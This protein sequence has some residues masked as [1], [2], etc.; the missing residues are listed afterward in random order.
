LSNLLVA[1]LLGTIRLKL[2]PS[3]DQP[4]MRNMTR[5]DSLVD[6]RRIAESLPIDQEPPQVLECALGTG[7][8]F[9]LPVGW[10]SFFE[11]DEVSAVVTGDAFVLDND[12][13]SPDAAPDRV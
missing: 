4:L 10:W 7:E 5:V 12:F 13:S 11:W 3:W 9:F 6:G 2:V 8:L 1:P